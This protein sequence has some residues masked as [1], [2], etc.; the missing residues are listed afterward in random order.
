MK[1]SPFDINIMLPPATP[2]GRREIFQSFVGRTLT[3]ASYLELRST[4]TSFYLS[5]Y[6]RGG[7]PKMRTEKEINDEIISN[8][9]DL[10]QF[11]D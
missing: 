7:I 8:F 4:L 9:P 3:E 6:E 2:I 5:V 10:A 1:S 11:L